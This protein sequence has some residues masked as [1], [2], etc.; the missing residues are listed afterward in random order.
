MSVFNYRESPGYF[1]RLKEALSVTKKDLGNRIDRLMGTEG[2]PITETQMEELE[3]ILVMADIGVHTAMEIVEKVRQETRGQAVLTGTGVR[4]AIRSVLL[5]ILSANQASSPV[6]ST[7][8]APQVIFVLGVNGVGKTTT[9]GKLAHLLGSEGRRVLVC[10]AD[11]FRAA[12]VEQLTIWA[13]RTGTE[14]IKQGSGADPAAVLFDAITAGKAREKD[15][16]LVDTAG[17]LHTKTNLMQEI[18]K[19]KRVAGKEVAG[20]PH[21]VYLV[22][23]ATTGQNGL[24]QAR[25]FDQ[26]IGVTGLIVTKLDGT[27]KGGVLVAIAKELGVPILYIGVGEKQEDLV[28]FSAEAFVDSLLSTDG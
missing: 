16:V 20:A 23:D 7:G 13:E 18:E 17:R 21:Q 14:I 5:E 11:T 1:S 24:A 3:D 4:R 22:M 2:S 10:A 27:A 8:G 9:V 12:A 15:F 28:P 25:E 26:R 6:A 19:M